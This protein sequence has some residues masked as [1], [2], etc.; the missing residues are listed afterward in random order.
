MELNEFLTNSP[1]AKMVKLPTTIVVH[2]T[3]YSPAEIAGMKSTGS[4]GP[5]PREEE[6]CELEV[7]TEVIARGRIVKKKGEYF[8]KITEVSK[9]GTV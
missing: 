7:N 8:F 3:A 6:I 5:I 1:I 4:Y 2:R 9:E